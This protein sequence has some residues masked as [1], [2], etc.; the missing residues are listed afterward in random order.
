M[1]FL[2]DIILGSECLYCGERTLQDVPNERNF[3]FQIKHCKSC[4][5]YQILS[6][7]PRC[8]YCGT[9]QT[10]FVEDEEGIVRPRCPLCGYTWNE[11]K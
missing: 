7:R 4:G 9:S 10:Q 8:K 1:G 5:R 3:P 11:D 2:R 6:N